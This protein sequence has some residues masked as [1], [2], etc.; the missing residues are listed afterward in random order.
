M[1]CRYAI[2]DERKHDCID[3]QPAR[4]ITKLTLGGQA[5]H[6]H[7]IRNGL[8]KMAEDKDFCLDIIVGTQPIYKD[9]YY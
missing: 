2:H 9:Q 6:L 4:L 5:Q 7:R 3:V 1:S 8:E